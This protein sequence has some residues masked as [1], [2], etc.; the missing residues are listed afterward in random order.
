MVV[1]EGI[2]TSAE[3]ATLKDLKVAYGQGYLLGRPAALPKGTFSQFR[4]GRRAP[5]Q[6]PALAN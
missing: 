4:L 1:A 6:T 5:D 2:E 3:L